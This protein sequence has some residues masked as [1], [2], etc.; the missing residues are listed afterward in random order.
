MIVDRLISM[1]IACKHY[2]IFAR[3]TDLNTKRAF[4]P[5]KCKITS[6]SVVRR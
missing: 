3:M 4:K 2:V 5:N 1:T 6:K